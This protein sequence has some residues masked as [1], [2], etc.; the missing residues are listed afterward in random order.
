[1]PRQMRIGSV[2]GHTD[3]LSIVLLEFFVV[4]LSFFQLRRSDKGEVRRVEAEY[5]T[6][7]AVAG[8]VD[9]LDVMLKKGVKFQ[10]GERLID[11]NHV[12]LLI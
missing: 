1:M 5:K 3:D 11:G 2:C 7:A 4:V 12:F 10:V 8:K 9:L 6:F